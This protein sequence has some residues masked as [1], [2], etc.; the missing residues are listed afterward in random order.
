MIGCRLAAYIIETLGQKFQIYLWTDCSTGVQWVDRNNSNKVYVRNRVG[1]IFTLRG[2]LKFELRH[3]DS[4]DNPADLISRGC[5]M[6]T[7]RSSDLWKSGPQ[8]LSNEADWPETQFKVSITEIIT[9]N[10]PVE[11]ISS[12]FPVEKYSSLTK[13]MNITDVVFK[14]LQTIFP[15]KFSSLN[16]SDYWLRNQQ[17]VHYP[18]VYEALKLKSSENKYNESRK[19][20][21]NLSLYLDDKGII[22][23]KGKLQNAEISYDMKNPVLLP[24]K[25]HLCKLLV[26][27]R[28]CKNHH[29][30]VQE[31]LSFMREEF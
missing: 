7:L 21:S 14:F 4:K 22:R 26:E 12:I 28:H 13:F 18:L 25:S 6:E 16:S 2:Q 9:Q 29:T 23:Y 31:T 1:E 17:Q 5:S 3:V 10:I 11:P 15:G 24:P 19:F 27:D 20:I 30:G 8:W